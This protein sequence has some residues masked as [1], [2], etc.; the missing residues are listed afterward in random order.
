MN[1]KSRLDLPTLLSP[2]MRILRVV[3]TS[4]SI[5]TLLRT[6]SSRYI[7]LNMLITSDQFLNASV[8]FLINLVDYLLSTT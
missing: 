8:Y 1:L 2:M 4:S 3:S 6:A 7:I 5:L